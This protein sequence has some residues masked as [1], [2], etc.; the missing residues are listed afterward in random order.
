MQP[1]QQRITVHYRQEVIGSKNP[2]EWIYFKAADDAMPPLESLN[3]SKQSKQSDITNIED[4][5]IKRNNQ[6]KK[7][8]QNT[9]NILKENKNNLN[10]SKINIIDTEINKI[11]KINEMNLLNESL[12]FKNN[13]DRNRYSMLHSDSDSN[14]DSPVSLTNSTN[15]LN[16]IQFDRKRKYDHSKNSENRPLKRRRINSMNNRSIKRSIK[17]S[18]KTGDTAT[19][20]VTSLGRASG[21]NQ[22]TRWILIGHFVTIWAGIIKCMVM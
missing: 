22:V 7:P 8:N 3:K 17:G 6:K 21:R 19:A 10:I 15:Q 4:T 20:N 14:S 1:T 5:S 13:L 12:I 18:I 16:I 9:N 11:N 2:D